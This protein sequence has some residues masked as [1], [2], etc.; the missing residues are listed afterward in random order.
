MASHRGHASVFPW[1]TDRLAF[2][3]IGMTARG[4]GFRAGPW[5]GGPETVDEPLLDGAPGQRKV[6]EKRL[7]RAAASICRLPGRFRQPAG[8]EA[9]IE[10]EEQR[11][12]LNQRPSA[13]PLRISRHLAAMQN[14]VRS[15]D[16]QS[17]HV[18]RRDDALED[19]AETGGDV[20][21]LRSQLKRI[22]E[23]VRET[24]FSKNHRASAGEPTQD[25]DPIAAA[26]LFKH[27]GGRVAVPAKHDD[28]ARRLPAVPD[29]LARAGF[30]GLEKRPLLRQL[31]GRI[32]TA[33]EIPLARHPVMMRAVH[34]CGQ[35]CRYTAAGEPA[36]IWVLDFGRAATHGHDTGDRDS[37]EGGGVAALE[38]ARHRRRR[39]RSRRYRRVARSCLKRQLRAACL[40]AS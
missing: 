39:G 21:E 5:N 38:L 20:C 31:R 14:Q 37:C 22:D 18:Q 11:A 9:C 19:P 24:S 10:V 30:C 4:S 16:A 15:D 35:F 34:P 13:P 6:A 40:S 26:R 28:R 8:R 3:E 12:V 32:Q 33:R 36:A 29:D 25:F 2:A 1:Q 23:R 27:V 7:V 17:S